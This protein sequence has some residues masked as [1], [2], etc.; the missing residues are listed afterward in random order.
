M[1]EPLVG[2]DPLKGLQVRLE[3]DSTRRRAL[4]AVS[5]TASVALAAVAA[6]SLLPWQSAGSEGG[7]GPSQM[8]QAVTGL[9]QVPQVAIAA[10]V[11]LMSLWVARRSE[12][13]AWANLVAIPAGVF[14]GVWGISV[15]GPDEDGLVGAMG[16]YVTCAAS[17]VALA[18]T[19]ALA[20]VSLA[21]RDEVSPDANRTSRAVDWL[22]LRS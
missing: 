4:V 15:L 13:W 14:C 22:R 9:Q 5:M 19:L 18:A 8:A 7:F 6:A 3:S 11:G 2:A 16:A 12:R 1:S 10:V 20:W 21:A 17:M